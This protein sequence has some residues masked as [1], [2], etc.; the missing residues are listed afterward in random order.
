MITRDNYDWFFMLY[1]DNELSPAERRI[2]EAFVAENVDLKAEL[3]I[4]LQC[5]LDPEPG[6][7]FENRESLLKQSPVAK[8]PL[9]QEESLLLY[10]DGELDED[11]RRNVESLSLRNPS[12]LRE[13]ALLQQTVIEPDPALVFKN[14]EQL[15]KK[16]RDRRIV[17]LPI[18]RIVAAASVLLAVGL[19]VFNILRKNTVPSIAGSGK[20]ASAK[21]SVGRKDHPGVTPGHADSLNLVMS[22]PQVPKRQTKMINIRVKRP[23]AGNQPARIENDPIVSPRQVSGGLAELAKINTGKGITPVQID[24]KFTDRGNMAIRPGD[25][26]A[27][28]VNRENAK[29]SSFATEALHDEMAAIATVYDSGAGDDGGSDVPKKNKL[30]GVFR[31]VSRVFEKNANRDDDDKRG[32][33][34]GNLQIAL[35]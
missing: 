13:L 25:E 14:K 6:L 18:L 15:Y 11:A 27:P 20:L 10:I 16:E 7:F 17:F 3:D 26:A 19:L 23:V 28:E 24:R 22:L 30:R 12:I 5:R 2:V 34:I 29:G 32:I 8:K 21:L 35:K 33:L 1:V 9:P 4:L 31:K